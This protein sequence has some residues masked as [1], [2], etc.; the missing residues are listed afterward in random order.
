MVEEEVKSLPNVIYIY[1]IGKVDP[2]CYE[3]V[4]AS[5]TGPNTN[6]KHFL[7]Q[8]TFTQFEQPGLAVIA[9]KFVRT[10]DVAESNG[11]TSQV[12]V[13]EEAISDTGGAAVSVRD[14]VAQRGVLLE[15]RTHTIQ[16][17]AASLFAIHFENDKPGDLEKIVNALDPSS[18]TGAMQQRA[19]YLHLASLVGGRDE[20]DPAF[21]PIMSAVVIYRHCI[22]KRMSVLD[23]AKTTKDEKLVSA[24]KLLHNP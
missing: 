1:V 10:K 20:G 9:A 12:A 16:I 11:F 19:S 8:T 18:V 17:M 21:M 14:V 23:Y 24:V 6:A 4:A 15:R 22:K 2:H 5:A 7:L 13:W 3:V